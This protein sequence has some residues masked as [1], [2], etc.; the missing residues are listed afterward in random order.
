ML[1]ATGE[2]K[3]DAVARTVEG[4]VT[5]FF[6]AS[7]LQLHPH[8]SVVVDEAAAGQLR[9]RRLL[10]PGLRRQARRGRASSEQREARE[11]CATQRLRC[12][13][14]RRPGR[15]G[16]RRCD[17]CSAASTLPG[18]AEAA[19]RWRR[20]A[21]SAKLVPHQTTASTTAT[22][23]HRQPRRAVDVE[24]RQGGDDDQHADRRRGRGVGAVSVRRPERH[25]AAGRRTPLD[26]HEAAGERRPQR[27]GR[28]QPGGDE[29]EGDEVLGRLMQPERPPSPI[30]RHRPDAIDADRLTDLATS[31]ITSGRNGSPRASIADD[32]VG[33]HPVAAPPSSSP[34]SQ[35]VYCG[36]PSR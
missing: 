7:A 23:D 12:G 32:R 24:H 13:R 3:A 16:A 22:I 2:A 14:R 31:S 18:V 8:V 26:E 17:R 10:P 6:P 19:R 11:G 28:L 1:V 4:P 36:M 27:I 15:R 9:A 34:A 29:H 33:D 25:P 35:A 21:A 20:A 30:R 5:A